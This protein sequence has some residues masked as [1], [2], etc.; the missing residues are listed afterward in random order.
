MPSWYVPCARQHRLSLHDL[1]VSRFDIY[2]F[3]FTGAEDEA[4]MAETVDKL[5]TLIKAEVDSGIPHERIILGG[6]SQGGAMTLLTGLQTDIKFAGLVMLSTW[7]PLAKKL[8][9]VR[10]TSLEGLACSLS[11]SVAQDKSAVKNT[12]FAQ[13]SLFWGHGQADPLVQPQFANRSSNAS[14]LFHPI[15]SPLTWNLLPV[16]ALKT[17]FGVTEATT[18]AQLPIGLTHHTYPGMGHSTCPQELQHLK[19]WLS[20]VIPATP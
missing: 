7:L 12:H 1:H 14:Y 17:H 4:G 8:I 16:D 5:R 9:A 20:T 3:G 13:L 15:F 11:R 6:F 19:Q 2:D 10:S 18:S